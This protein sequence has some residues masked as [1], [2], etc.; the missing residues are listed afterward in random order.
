MQCAFVIANLMHRMAVVGGEE[1]EHG[2]G[3]VTLI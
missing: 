3:I 1:G 2:F